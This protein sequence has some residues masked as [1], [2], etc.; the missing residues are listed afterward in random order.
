MTD[1]AARGKLPYPLNLGLAEDGQSF[2][3]V[4]AAKN[5]QRLQDF[6]AAFAALFSHGRDQAAIMEEGAGLLRSLVAHDDWLP[7]DYAEPQPDRYA[8]YLL[9]ADPAGRFSV[10]SF[11]WGPGQS[12]PIH[13]HTVWGLIGVLRGAE[14]SQAY[15]FEAGRGLQVDGEPQRLSVGDV[16][17]V[18]PPLHDIHRVANAFADQASISI[19]VYGADIG[20][21]K[22][23]VYTEDGQRKPFI[24]GYSNLL[25]P[26]LAGVVSEHTV[27]HRSYAWVRQALL[28]RRELA[29]LD[30]REEAPFALSHPLF[31]AN[32]PFSQL[33]LQA[34]RRLPR[35][36]V[37]IVVYDDGEGLALPAARRLR[38]L[39]YT[40]VSL[41]SGGLAGWAA[42]GG[43]L[44]QDV[45]APSKAFGELVEAERHTPSLAATEVRNLI[46][47]GADMVVVDARRFDEYQVMNIPGST[48]MPGAE[49]VQR[50]RELAPDPA[51][52]I[53]VNC[54]GRTRSIIGTQSLINAGVPN[55][56]YA[57]RN[58]TIGW[59]LAGLTLEHGQSRRFPDAVDA[60]RAAQARAQARQVADRAGVQRIDWHGLVALREPHRSVYCLDVRQAERYREGHLA[61]FANAPGGQLVQETDHIAPVRG[62]RLVLCDH[63]GDTPGAQADMTASWLAQMGWEVYVLDQACGAPLE[64]GDAPQALPAEPEV[65]RIDAAQLQQWLE[66]DD[67][68][69]L[70]LAGS[71]EYRRGHIRDAGFALRS[72]FSRL[73]R[74][75]PTVARVVLTSPD[76]RLAAYAAEDMQQA[77]QAA[78]RRA[79]VFVLQGGSASWPALEADG[80]RW[81]SEP[82][83]RYRRPYEGTDNPVAAMQAYLDWEYGLVAQLGRD[84]THGFKVI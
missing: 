57:L 3:I 35:R 50:V 43:E 29:L 22:R 17:A 21:I 30:V 60:E 67:A 80:P 32:M 84:G 82:E 71:A 45:N 11:V 24:S 5:L 15:R 77:L 38:S 23:S 10:V 2:L 36:D 7:P 16:E 44:F 46:D 68:L 78:G 9:H 20:R 14:Y 25:L 51:T 81:L 54:A 64:S 83:D 53:V 47:K 56:V 33:E 40:D 28:D 1:A 34:W 19:H 69:V 52:R 70:D 74:R 55:P 61:G 18:H 41:L 27:P 6:V 66:Q 37:T 76:G 31:A 65:A 39:G 73:A 63:A 42:S 62:A 8:Q 48:S 13:D 12:T 79:E 75:L 72:D 4:M 26:N 59:T 49:L 58:G